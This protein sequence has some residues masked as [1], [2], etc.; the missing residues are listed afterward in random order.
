MIKVELDLTMEETA[1]IE[2]LVVNADCKD[3]DERTLVRTIL[4][5]LDKAMM[6]VFD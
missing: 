2:D 4:E 6:R 5:K 3:E 1:H